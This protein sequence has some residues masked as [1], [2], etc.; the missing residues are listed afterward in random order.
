METVGVEAWIQMG[1]ERRE[2]SFEINLEKADSCVH[3][4][5]QTQLLWG[6]SG[7]GCFRFPAESEMSWRVSDDEI[8]S[9]LQEAIRNTRIIRLTEPSIRVPTSAA[10]D[11]DGVSA[12]RWNP[13]ADR[14]PVALASPSVYM[15]AQLGSERREAFADIPAEALEEG[16]QSHYAVRNGL[17]AWIEASVSEWL[18]GQFGRGWRTPEGDGEDESFMEA[19]DSVAASCLTAENFIP[20]TRA[21]RI[22]ELHGPR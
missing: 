5:Y 20:N 3:G 10:R 2:T 17:A 16:L 4:W 6:W 19:D 11:V 8:G 14:Q 7:L 18:Y 1:V 13:A 22:T 12:H 9:A 21:L 15:W